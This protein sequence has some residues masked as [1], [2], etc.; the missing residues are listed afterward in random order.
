M[1]RG[2]A[3]RPGDEFTN[4]NGYTYVKTADRGWVQKALLIA[5]G[6]LGRRLTSD[7]R[8]IFIDGD[9]RNLDPDNIKVTQKYNKQSA[10]AKLARL[11]EQIR[12]LTAQAD[13]LREAIANG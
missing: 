13:D 4:Q 1:P 6:K 5:E 10:Q 7:E 11:E 9:R 12:E 2:T 3:K 8:A